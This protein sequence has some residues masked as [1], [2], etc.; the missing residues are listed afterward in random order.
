MLLR[1]LDRLVA[2]V[3]RGLL[4]LA[5]D[6]VRLLRGLPLEVGRR[7]LGGLDA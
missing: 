7:R 6:P 3:L 2:R 1:G 5:P 4:G